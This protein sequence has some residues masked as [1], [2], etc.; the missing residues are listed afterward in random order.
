MKI[1]HIITKGET[2]TVNEKDQI[3]RTGRN[4]VTPSD[5][6]KL[7]GAVEYKFGRQCR[8]YT[9]D[10]IRR[11]EVPWKYKNGKQRCHIMDLDHGTARVWMSP[12]L[13]DVM[14]TEERK[15]G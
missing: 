11:Q 12:G 8:V 7:M 5:H 10:E 13:L 9:N 3:E 2:F 4:A 1:I 14:V 6:W 15:V